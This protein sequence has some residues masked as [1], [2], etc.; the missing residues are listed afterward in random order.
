MILY[1]PLSR[2]DIFPVDES[3][4]TKRCCVSHQGRTL[5]VE[6]TSDGNYQLLQLLSTDPNDFMDTTYVPGATF[7]M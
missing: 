5:Y 4:F 1:S 3:S 7:K 2:D 6:E